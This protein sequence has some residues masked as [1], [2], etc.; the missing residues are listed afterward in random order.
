ML[1]A[2]A[3]A[4]VARPGGRAPYASPV[5]LSPST[6]SLLVVVALM[7]GVLALVMAVSTYRRFSGIQA[8]YLIRWADAQRDLN[9]VVSHQSGK[10]DN[11]R[12]DVDVV[13]AQLSRTSDDLE[14]SLR[15]VAIVRDDA[16]GDLSGKL[17]FSAAILDDHGD[18][19]VISSVHVLGESRTFAKGVLEGLSHITLTPEEQQALSAAGTGKGAW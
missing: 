7:V 3:Q 6:T 16:C 14:Q 12:S 9:A 1:A 18:G 11:L 17:S 10:I 4:E 19:L 5:E 15:H 13:R 8:R 2:R